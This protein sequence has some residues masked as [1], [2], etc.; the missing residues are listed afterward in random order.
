VQ[1]GTRE[2]EERVVKRSDWMRGKGRGKENHGNHWITSGRIK[3]MRRGQQLKESRRSGKPCKGYMNSV[4]Q[5]D[6]NEGRKTEVCR[7]VLSA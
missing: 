4:E 5:Q 7:A 1:K 3:G 2:R 6:K